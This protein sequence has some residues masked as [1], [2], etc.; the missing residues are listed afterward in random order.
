ML[1]CY[2]VTMLQCSNITMIFTQ[3][4]HIAFFHIACQTLFCPW[5][6]LLFVC[7]FVVV[8]MWFQLCF[9]MCFSRLWFCVNLFWQTLHWKSF[10]PLCIFT[11]CRKLLSL[12]EVKVQTLQLTFSPVCSLMCVFICDALMHA[13]GQ[14]SHLCGFT[15]E[16]FIKCWVRL[17]FVLVLNVHWLQWNGFTPVCF[18]MCVVRFTFNAV[19]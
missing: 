13:K 5:L 9:F 11:C 2:N 15:P 7:L 4:F 17:L 6:F 10:T 19:S 3:I 16:C 8:S 18:F 14:I 12:V 1:Q